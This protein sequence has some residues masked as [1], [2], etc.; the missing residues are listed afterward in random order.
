MPKGGIYLHKWQKN[1][2]VTDNLYRKPNGFA[3][4]ER[5]H[6]WMLTQKL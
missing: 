6:L 5:Y 2:L 4:C 3:F 1:Q